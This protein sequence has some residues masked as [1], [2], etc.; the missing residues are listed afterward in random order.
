MAAAFTLEKARWF[1]VMACLNPG[2]VGGGLS[3]EE[4]VALAKRHGFKAVEFGIEWLAQ[5][6]EREGEEAARQWLAE[7]AIRHAAFW[8]PVPWR[9]DEPKFREGLNSLPAKARTAQAVGCTACVTYIPPAIEGDPKEFRAMMV[10]RFREIC[11]VLADYGV[12]LGIEWV[13]PAHFRRSGNPVLWRMDQALALCDEVAAPNIGLLVD[14]FHWFCAQHSLDELQT[15]P[16]ERIVHV[17]INDAPDRPVEEQGDNERVMPGDGIIDL[18]G[19]LR[20]LKEAGYNGAVS[21]E[22]LSKT[23]PQQ[24]SKDELAAKAKRG[25]DKIFAHL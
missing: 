16:K 8:L 2:T 18:V 11:A 23:L 15:L 19:F 21:V 20:A 10:R 24:F 7:Q 4:F 6:G 12:S 1:A 5:K 14:S 3:Y 13:A 9:E 17:H 22:V 25:L